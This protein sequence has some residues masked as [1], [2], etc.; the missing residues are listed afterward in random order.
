MVYINKSKQKFK[1]KRS[2]T[3]EEKIRN[4]EHRISELQVQLKRETR[5][6]EVKRLMDE[7]SKHRKRIH[8]L[9]EQI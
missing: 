6:G 1:M 7:I 3:N 2:S 8:Q 5:S 9:K 4:L